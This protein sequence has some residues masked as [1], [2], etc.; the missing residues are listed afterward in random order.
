MLSKV[1]SLG[2]EEII[3]ILEIISLFF[4]TLT[5][6]FLIRTIFY[7]VALLQQK[8]R[9]PEKYLEEQQQ[10]LAQRK[11]PEQKKAERQI[12]K[13]RKQLEKEL[14]RKCS[15]EGITYSE[16]MLEE[17]IFIRLKRVIRSEIPEDV[18]ERLTQLFNDADD[19]LRPGW[20]GTAK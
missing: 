14:K 6:F 16:N 4:G 18:Q 8:Y 19:E 17:A 12:A 13:E 11:T 2:T 7:G 20:T 15:K 10:E 5:V 9:H 1:I 3:R